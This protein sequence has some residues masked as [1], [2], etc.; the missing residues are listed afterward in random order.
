MRVRFSKYLL[1]VLVPVGLSVVVSACRP[2]AVEEPLLLLD[3]DPAESLPLPKGPV[4]D[5]SRC[6]V[7]H[8]NYQ[9]ER[10]AVRHARANVG[11]EKCHGRSDKHCGDEDNITPPE[12]MYP[13]ARIKPACM[14]CH[15]RKKIDI[16][17][18][19]P[20]FAAGSRKC[21]T[22]CHGSHR[23]SHR[24]RRWNKTTGKLIADDKVR[25]LTTQPTGGASAP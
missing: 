6:H 1:W 17:K 19:K 20:L 7:C 12:I 4:A 10:L 18:H 8:I 14:A 15:P 13:R 25:M 11:C 9:S 2:E 21:C 24:T 3:D 22:D 5:N 23:L 16:P